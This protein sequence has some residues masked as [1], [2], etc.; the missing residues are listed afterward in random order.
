MVTRDQGTRNFLTTTTDIGVVAAG[1]SV[2]VDLSAIRRD[3][4]VN[5]NTMIITNNA[6]E[7][8]K[9]ALDGKDVGHVPSGSGKFSIDWRDHLTFSVIELTN[10]HATDSSSADE[11]RVVVGRTG[12][13]DKD[14][15]P[16]GVL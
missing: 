16:K 13:E 7:E 1:A 5:L 6:A 10:A 14:V 9:I 12:P 15:D 8:F 11:V 2:L 4:G 3:H